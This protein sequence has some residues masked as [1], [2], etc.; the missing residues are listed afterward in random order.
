MK[1]PS[2]YLQLLAASSLILFSAAA[3]AQEASR[4]EPPPGHLLASAPD[5]GEWVETF[6]YQQTLSPSG[7]PVASPGQR[8]MEQKVTTTK[9]GDVVHE[10]MVNGLGEVFD[11]WLVGGVQYTHQSGSSIWIEAHP[12]AQGAGMKFTGLPANG[13][14]DLDWISRT[15]YLGTAVRAGRRYLVFTPLASNGPA[16]RIPSADQYKELGSYA[17]IDFDSRLP[18]EVKDLGATRTYQF[19]DLPREKQPLPPDL[20]KTL[21]DIEEMRAR[22]SPRPERPY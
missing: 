4:P 8:S 20:A 13:F 3:P 18:F 16:G 9:T 2:P 12:G 10:Q 19:S 11:R 21:K 15:N 22:I 14:R 5:Y 6:D 17:L 1:S 7:A